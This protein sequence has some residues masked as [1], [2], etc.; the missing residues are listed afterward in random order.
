ML[1]VNIESVSSIIRE[2][3]K[4][5][6]LPRFR[7][8]QKNDISYEVGDDPVTVA[9]A[10]AEKALAGRLMGLLPDSTVVGEEDYAA[11]PEIL[12]RFDGESPVW[13]VDPI[14]GTRNF[15]AGSPVFGVIVALSLQNQTVA[16]W[17]YDPVSGDMVASDGGLASSYSLYV[18]F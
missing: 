7:N 12:R 2:V 16:G 4:T 6:I 1:K 13:I 11:N 15:V 17:I 8:L 5:E 18:F 9:D 3:S 10:A 14:D